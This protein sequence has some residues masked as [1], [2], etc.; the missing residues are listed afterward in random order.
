MLSDNRIILHWLQRS[1]FQ[2]LKVTK[3]SSGTQG[4]IFHEIEGAQ[5]RVSINRSNG[6]NFNNYRIPDQRERL[7]SRLEQHCT[8]APLYG[9]FNEQRG[10]GCGEISGVLTR[11]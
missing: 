11:N 4:N 10:P 8:Y 2:E 9:A 6:L 5:S 7:K 1:F 3:K